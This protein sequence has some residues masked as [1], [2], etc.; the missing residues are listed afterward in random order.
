MVVIDHRAYY[1]ER[2]MKHYYEVELLR[3]LDRFEEAVKA[4]DARYRYPRIERKGR[5]LYTIRGERADLR[6]RP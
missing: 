3:A 2:E 5:T 4:E 6:K 1:Q